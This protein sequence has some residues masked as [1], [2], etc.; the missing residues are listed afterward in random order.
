[1]TLLLEVLTRQIL[2]TVDSHGWAGAGGATNLYREALN[3]SKVGI[4]PYLEPIKELIT[5]HGDYRY[6]TYL[7]SLLFRGALGMAFYFFFC[8]AAF[9]LMRDPGACSVGTVQY[10]KL[11]KRRICT[12]DWR[13]SK[14]PYSMYGADPTLQFACG[15]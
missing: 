7:S 14:L 6:S 12:E 4:V 15:S 1:M 9:R 10:L 11:Q 3:V 5:V 2:L 13:P 8:L